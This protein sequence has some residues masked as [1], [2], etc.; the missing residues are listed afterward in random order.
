MVSEEIKEYLKQRKQEHLEAY[1]ERLSFEKQAE[2]KRQL[3]GL[4]WNILD[5]SVHTEGEIKRGTFSPIPALGIDEIEERRS[6]YESC[7]LEAIK[8]GEIAAVLLAGGQGSRLGFDGPKGTYNIGETKEISIFSLLVRNLKAVAEKAGVWIHLY[9]MT[10]EINYE[11]TV[12][13]FSEKNFFGYPEGYIHFFVQDM[14][15]AV[16]FEGKLYMSAADR[17][18]YSPNG[19]GGWFMTMVKRGLLTHIHENGIKWL[20]V[21]SVDNVLQQIVDPVFVGA[22]L[23]GKVTC[24][25]K[26]IR[27]TNPQE[28]VGVLCCEDGVPSIVEYYDM[29]EDMA[30]QTNED[31]RLTYCYGVTLNYLFHVDNLERILDRTLPVH[32]AKK[33]I[34]YMK[35]DGEYVKASVENGYKFEYLVL[36]MIRYMDSCLACEVV[37]E[38]EFAPVKNLTGVDS[39]DTAR[40][41]LRSNGF[42]L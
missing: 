38:K 41:Y 18:F 21:F 33:K 9:I 32:L 23:S 36:D 40:E 28:K 35:P 12:E 1:F 34:D 29:P 25:A 17:L 16:D 39:V 6:E 7:G 2:L 4:D 22:T 11:K 27:K 26:V 5:I 19:N 8:R 15:P 37:R 24:G 10:S 20:N 42:V 31:G 3:D 14:A 30:K 13:F